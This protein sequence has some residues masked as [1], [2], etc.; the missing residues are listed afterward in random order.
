MSNSIRIAFLVNN[1]KELPA[2]EIDMLKN[3]YNSK[4]LSIEAF[5]ITNQKK[6]ETIR[7]GLKLFNTFENW[8]FRSLPNAFRKYIVSKE[9]DTIKII[10]EVDHKKIQALNLDVIYCSCLAEYSKKF[11]SQAKYGLWYFTFGSGDYSGAIPSAYWEVMNDS[12]ETGSTLMIQMPDMLDAF[13][14]YKG[15]TATV[16]YSVKNT[17]N[18]IAWKSSTFL[19]YR[20]TELLKIGP[21]LFFSKYKKL[22]T[23]ISFEISVD[24]YALPGNFK[25]TIFFIRNI[26]RYLKSKFLNLFPENRFTILFSQQSSKISGIDFTNFKH[27]KL[28][29]DTFWAD[30]F[31]VVSKEKTYFFFEE[32]SY[33]KNKAHISVLELKKDGSYP[34]PAIV[35]DR[36]YH[37][38]YPFVFESEGSFYMIPESSSNKTVEL[39]KCSEF[40]L[41][42]E[43]AENLMENIALIDATLLY[44]TGKWWLFGTRTD[45]S[46]TSTN[47]QLFLYWSETLFSPEWT[48]HPQNPV[49]TSISNC[50]P[51]GKL[52]QHD[53]KLYRPAQNN[54]S[55]QY[56]YAIKINEIE[57][58]NETEYREK[59]V[60][61][62]LPDK[63]NN[64]SAVHTIN[65]VN[66]MI[67]ID[68]ITK[69]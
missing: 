2:W 46:F 48:P 13:A 41:K 11:A 44:H 28:P 5:I 37:L 21:D 53:D 9:F 59:E 32:F 69:K 64:L 52:F 14:V 23:D 18:N 1:T 56:G 63:K 15:T 24:P 26:F 16:P 17:L 58:L 36:P 55:K 19:M 20:L 67:V 33:K 8:W 4:S 40:P 65:F 25:V 38:S 6:R 35:L 57:V 54:S 50:R 27:M 49:A 68:G 34:K 62:I 3:M 7:L 22:V 31:I 51:A 66:S 42:W 12:P 61:E 10:E 39:Y 29:K 47:D 60:F 30:P 45:H 43:F